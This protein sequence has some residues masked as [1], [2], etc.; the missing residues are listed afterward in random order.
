[1]SAV[2]STLTGDVHDEF[3]RDDYRPDTYLVDVETGQLVRRR[4]RFGHNGECVPFSEWLADQRQDADSEKS[5]YDEYDA[6]ETVGHY[7]DVEIS[8]SVEYRFRVPAYSE[9]EAKDRAKDLLLDATPADAFT[10]HTRT[11]E[12]ATIERQELPDDW[13]PYGGTPIWEAIDE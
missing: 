10:T 2:Q 11:D 12:R 9:H 8:Q 13:D 1:M 6:D 5:P 7:Y 3:N 4:N